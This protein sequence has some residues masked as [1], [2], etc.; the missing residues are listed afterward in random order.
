VAETGFLFGDDVTEFIL[1]ID[2]HALQAWGIHEQMGGAAVEPERTRL[3]NQLPRRSSG[4][5]KNS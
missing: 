5:T 4:S 1:E 3:A 2:R